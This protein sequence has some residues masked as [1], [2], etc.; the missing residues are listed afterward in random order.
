MCEV[1]GVGDRAVSL[2]YCTV[3]SQE[4]EIV[5]HKRTSSRECGIMVT[6]CVC[7]DDL[8]AECGWM[9]WSVGCADAGACFGWMMDGW[10]DE[11]YWGAGMGG[12]CSQC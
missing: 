2:S 4:S 1:K 7:V 3:S 8:D 5:H 11:A 12:L 9:V 10:M 6:V